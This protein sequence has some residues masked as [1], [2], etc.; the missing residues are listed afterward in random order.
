MQQLNI[1][2]CILNI[3]FFFLNQGHRMVS[4]YPKY[5]VSPHD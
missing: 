1:G 5:A 4:N 3:E 2:Y